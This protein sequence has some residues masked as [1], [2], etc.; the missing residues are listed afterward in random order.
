MIVEKIVIFKWS[1]IR[2]S[3]VVNGKN[4]FWFKHGLVDITND[5]DFRI[6]VLENAPEADRV[7][8]DINWA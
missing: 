8:V 4:E 2:D 6:F 7:L 5:A 1:E 3:K